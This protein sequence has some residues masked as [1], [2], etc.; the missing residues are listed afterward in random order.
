MAK[1]T[2]IKAQVNVAGPRG[3][4]FGGVF[5]QSVIE[6]AGVA[7]KDSNRPKLV[8]FAKELGVS[9]VTAKTPV[10]DALKS[11]KQAAKKYLAANFVFA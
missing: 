2:K 3:F 11:L 7:A 8:A 10:E 4:R 9:G 6:G 1:T 5:V